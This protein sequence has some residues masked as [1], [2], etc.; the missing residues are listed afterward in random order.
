M[1]PRDSGLVFRGAKNYSKA[2]AKAKRRGD[3]TPRTVTSSVDDNA[4]MIGI[5]PLN[6]GKNERLENDRNFMS[7]FFLRSSAAN[8]VL[9]LATDARRPQIS[10]TLWQFVLTAPSG[11]QNVEPEFLTCHGPQLSSCQH[12]AQGLLVTW[13]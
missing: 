7:R 8:Y 10:P 3:R 6:Q 4:A 5:T 12:K 1:H 9:D 2:R 13:M 11:D